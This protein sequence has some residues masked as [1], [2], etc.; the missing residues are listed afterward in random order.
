MTDIWLLN[1]TFTEYRS[2]N[3]ISK[4]TMRNTKSI[5]DYNDQLESCETPT[6]YQHNKIFTP[7]S[8]INAYFDNDYKNCSD[9]V[10]HPYDKNTMKHVLSTA[11]SENYNLRR[12]TE[13][14]PLYLGLP[15]KG[16]HDK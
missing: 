11:P 16:T 2:K 9:T 4:H 15:T 5:H 6:L 7:V 12:L 14:R 1:R 8:Q 10:V 13:D 3:T